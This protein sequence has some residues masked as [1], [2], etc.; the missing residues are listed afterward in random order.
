M[1][2]LNV[3]TLSAKDACVGTLNGVDLKGYFDNL[4][5]V[6][7]PAK[8][9]ALNIDTLA[10][11]NILLL[12][13]HK[14]TSIYILYFFIPAEQLNVETLNVVDAANVDSKYRTLEYELPKSIRIKGDVH[15]DE[16]DGL[17][18][19]NDIEFMEYLAMV[20]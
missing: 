17:E 19:V 6:D 15:I 13:I 18:L 20:Y 7:K 10:G 5:T 16:I 4:L 1:P 2:Y 9:G 11:M 14:L 3:S 12:Y 8:F